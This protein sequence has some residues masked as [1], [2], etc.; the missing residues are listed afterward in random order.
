MIRLLCVLAL[1]AA[2]EPAVAQS[3]QAVATQG[4]EEQKLDAVGLTILI[5]SSIMALEHANTTGN[6]SVLRDLGTPAFREKFDQTRLSTVFANLRSRQIT[7]NPS[8]LL[9][10]NL[11]KQPEVTAQNQLHLV[12]TFPTKPS[13][14]QFELWFLNLNGAWRIEGIMVD[15]VPVQTT[16]GVQGLTKG[17]P[18]KGTPANALDALRKS[19]EPDKKTQKQPN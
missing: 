9:S 12:G 18:T 16:Q 3:N 2:G 4:K 10:P 14:I 8:L 6:Y 11:T 13:Q 17:T 1:V 7:L 19:N 5:K 15:A